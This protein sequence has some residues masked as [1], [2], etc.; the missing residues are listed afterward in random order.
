MRWQFSG[1]LTFVFERNIPGRIS[2]KRQRAEL[3]RK[4]KALSVSAGTFQAFLVQLRR[5]SKKKFITFRAPDQPVLQLLW[6]G[7]RGHAVLLRM[8]GQVPRN[9]DGQKSHSR[10]LACL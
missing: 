2:V 4:K 7:C 5:C 10:A 6:S 3:H 9:L 1:C 8:P